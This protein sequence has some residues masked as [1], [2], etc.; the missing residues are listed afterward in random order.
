MGNETTE[1]LY[2]DE[3]SGGPLR[4]MPTLDEALV[5]AIQILTEGLPESKGGIFKGRGYLDEAYSKI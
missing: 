3:E 1:V 5:K 4:E 2:Q